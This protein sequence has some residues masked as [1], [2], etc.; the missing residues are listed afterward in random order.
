MSQKCK[1]KPSAKTSIIHPIKQYP[2]TSAQWGNMPAL[3]SSDLSWA[4]VYVGVWKAAWHTEAWWLVL[5]LWWRRGGTRL[6]SK[7]RGRIHPLGK[8]FREE[9]DKR[10]M[11]IHMES[12]EFRIKRIYLNLMIDAMHVLNLGL[13]VCFRGS[14]SAHKLPNNINAMIWILSRVD[15]R[16][17]SC[18]GS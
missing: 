1:P 9:G 5:K 4:S 10:W 8:V 11:H 16:S 15:T 14:E 2:V 17:S 7:S 13:V 12:I 18:V 3:L 6:R